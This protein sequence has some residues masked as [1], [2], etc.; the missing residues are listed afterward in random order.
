MPTPAPDPRLLSIHDYTYVLPPERIAPEPLPNRDQ[1]R[2]LVYR[3]GQLTDQ[4]F[5]DLPAEQI[6]RAHV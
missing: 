5:R 4:T 1:A 3:D 6:G 2:L